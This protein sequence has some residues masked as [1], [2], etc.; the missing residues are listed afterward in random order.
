MP[1]D[2]PRLP[3]RLRTRAFGLYLRLPYATSLLPSQ[4]LCRLLRRGPVCAV[5]GTVPA[6]LLYGRDPGVRALLRT[7]LQLALQRKTRANAQM[8]QDA[9]VVSELGTGAGYYLDLGACM[10]VK[11]SN[12][13]LLQ[14]EFGWS[15][16]LVEANP[17][18]VPD[19]ERER[20]GDRT[21]VVAKGVGARSSTEELVEYGPLSSLGRTA[22]SDLYGDLRAQRVAAGGNVLTVDVVGIAELLAQVGAPARIHYASID[23]EGAD[24]EVVEAFPFDQYDVRLLTIEH[25][26]NDEVLTALDARLLPLG[27]QRVLR[28]WSSIDAWYVR[29]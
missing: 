4:L 15:G 24:L 19:L 20:S 14:D 11:Y 5:A 21:V 27:F 2:R 17:M 1:T 13:F 26:F 16:V 6:Y 28:R 3:S 12:T 22:S 7:N 23:I 29:R 10:P 18:L 25:N 9:W 8:L